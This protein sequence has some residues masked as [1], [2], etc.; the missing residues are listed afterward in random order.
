M[1]IDYSKLVQLLLPTFLRKTFLIELFRPL[2]IQ[3][4]NLH[5]QFNLRL[6]DARYKANINAS[7]VALTHL[8]QHELDVLVTID[9]MDGKPTDFKVIVSGVVDEQRLR[10]L[11]NQ[12]K[13]AGRSFIFRIGNVAYSCGFIN[14]ACEDITVLYF[15]EFTDHA[16]EDDGGVQIS[17]YITETD[18]V[19]LASR[20]VYSELSISGTVLGRDSQGVQ[21]Y[22]GTFDVIIAEHAHVGTS[23]VTL[24]TVA[25]AYY[26]IAEGSVQITPSSDSYYSYIYKP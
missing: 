25:E 4:Q 16:C 6:N 11:I 15:V 26:F 13:I 20:N 12:Y 14:H 8:I 7:V 24:N 22:A 3:L 19:F 5:S 21:F 1:N 23:M 2:V 17:G 18:A 9:E 10:S